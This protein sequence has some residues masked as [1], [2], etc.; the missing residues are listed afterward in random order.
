VGHHE[1]GLASGRQ[2]ELAAGLA[3]RFGDDRVNLQQ[4]F[5]RPAPP[6]RLQVRPLPSGEREKTT[7]ARSPLFIA[8]GLAVATAIGIDVPLFV[9]E[10]GFIGINVPLTAARSGSLSTRTTHPF[11][12]DRFG[13]ALDRLGIDTQIHNPYSLRTKGEVVAGSRNLGL[14]A[15]LAP[16]S[17]S[18]SHPEAG[19]YFGLLQGNC[20]YCYPCIIRRASLHHAGLDTPKGYA[21]NVLKLRGFIEATSDRADAVRAVV[22]SL[23]QRHRWSDVLRTGPIPADDRAAFDGVYRRGRQE[24]LDWLSTASDH[25]LTSRLPNRLR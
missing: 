12:M 11:F 14:L 13:E 24:I 21:L 23:G 4:L 15:E 20:G 22:R 8:A 19:R 18:C 5:L 16:R 1:G 9:P 3:T 2:R 17:L 7:R 25:R 6:N 10:N